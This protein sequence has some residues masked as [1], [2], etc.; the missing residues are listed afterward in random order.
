MHIFASFWDVNNNG[1]DVTDLAVILTVIVGF[2]TA[3]AAAFRWSR[4]QL[5]DEIRDV[6]RHEIT[7]ATQSIQPGANG[8]LSLPDV[9]R[10]TDRVEKMLRAIAAHQGIS[11]DE[12]MDHI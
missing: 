6:V 7:A 12:E 10:K 2:I 1:F 5:R 8:S 9:A 11:I 3:V 4:T